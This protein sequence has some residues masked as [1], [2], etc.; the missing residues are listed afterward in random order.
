[1]TQ[2]AGGKF[3][4]DMTLD[5]RMAQL[6]H[7]LASKKVLLVLDDLWEPE[8]LAS[9]DCVDDTTASKVLMSSR[10]RV[11]LIGHARNNM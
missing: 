6:K 2:V 1:M 5:K 4:D 10:V 7:I 9:L 3:E 11:Q 8:L